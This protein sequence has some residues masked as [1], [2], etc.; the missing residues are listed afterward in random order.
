[1]AKFRGKNAVV[2][3]GA[4]AVTQLTDWSLSIEG[5][6]IDTSEIG[7]DWKSAVQG[8]RKWS[9]SVSGILDMDDYT[10]QKLLIDE[11]YGTSTDGSLASVCFEVDEG[12][13]DGY[14]SGTA[15]I[16]NV[17]I[18]NPGNDDVVRV[19]MTLSGDGAL[20]YTAA[21]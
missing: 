4:N 17:T 19:S 2:N 13:A 18:N 12:T 15:I 8:S 11:I 1:M 3:I 10:G 21:T 14:F 16:T 6:E 5:T 20:T 7:S 9:G